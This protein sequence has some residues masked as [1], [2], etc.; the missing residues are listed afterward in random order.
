MSLEWARAR[1]LGHDVPLREFLTSGNRKRWLDLTVKSPAA[2]TVWVAR[3]SADRLVS[4]PRQSPV[5]SPL[6]RCG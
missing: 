1:A 4:L 3:A 2:M 6:D 5:K